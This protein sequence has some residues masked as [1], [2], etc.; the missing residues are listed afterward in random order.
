MDDDDDDE[1]YSEVDEK[2]GKKGRNRGKNWNHDTLVKLT[3]LCAENWEIINAEFDG[4]GGKAK[5]GITN[6]RKRDCWLEIT[7]KVNSLG[8][9]KRTVDQMRRKFSKIKSK[10]RCL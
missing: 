6:E 4:P 3:Q 5:G 9:T 10:G 8:H 2:G 7:E 1:E